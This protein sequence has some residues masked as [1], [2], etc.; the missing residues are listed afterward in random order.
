MTWLTFFLHNFVEFTH[1][2]Q[3]KHKIDSLQKNV[4][5]D[6]FFNVIKNE[7]AWNCL[8]L[9]FVC[10]SY[11]VKWNMRR[12]L[13]SFRNEKSVFYIFF[14]FIC[15]V[16]AWELRFCFF[17]RMLHDFFCVQ[18]NFFASQTSW[19]QQILWILLES[20]VIILENSW[21]DKKKMRKMWNL[22]ED[23]LNSIIQAHKVDFFL[24]FR[25]TF[26]LETI[27]AREKVLF[28]LLETLVTLLDVKPHNTKSTSLF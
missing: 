23:D 14:L 6:I 5:R 12:L 22:H 16:C 28:K 24:L 25:V 13:I 15:C 2:H 8:F 20:F 27:S 1:S 17:H 10:V 7:A 19:E 21:H 18:L 11:K 9:F 26:T 4:P 3:K